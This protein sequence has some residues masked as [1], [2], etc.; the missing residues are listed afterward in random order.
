MARFI[1]LSI[2]FFFIAFTTLAQPK[3]P[4]VPRRT[5]VRAGQSVAAAS[6]LA[7][8]V[9]RVT[10]QSPNL[11]AFERYGEHPVSLFTGLASIEIPLYTIQAGPISVPITLSY[12]AGGHKV[13]DAASWVGLGWSL[14][15]GG[16]IT[17]QQRGMADEAQTV[18]LLDRSIITDPYAYFNTPSCYNE[19]V[20]DYYERLATGRLDAERDIFSLR[21]PQKTNQ[22]ILPSQ[23]NAQWLNPDV[24]K[25]TFDRAANSFALTDEQG[26]RYAFATPENTANGYPNAWLISQIQ[27]PQTADQIRFNY[28]PVINYQ[29]THEIIESQTINDLNA[30]LLAAGESFPPVKEGIVF[31][32]VSTA[33]AGRLP[34]QVLFP[35]GKIE[36][37][38]QSTDRQDQNGQALDRVEIYAYNLETST[39]SLLKAAWLTYEYYTRSG[40]NGLEKMLMLKQVTWKDATGS[41]INQYSFTY[42]TATALPYV[43]SRAKDYWGYAN[44]QTGNQTLIPAQTITTSSPGGS[45]SIGGGERNPDEAAMQAWLLTAITYP[46]GGSASFTYEAHQYADGPAS[47]LAGGL[48]IRQIRRQADAASPAVLSTYVYGTNRDGN[49]RLRQALTL[50]YETEQTQINYVADDRTPSSSP[51]RYYRWRIRRFTSNAIPALFPQEGS[52]VTYTTVTEYSDNGTSANGTAGRTV[53]TF[54]DSDDERITLNRSANYFLNSKHWDRGQPLTQTVYG[55]DGNKRAETINTYQ[56]QAAGQTADLTG[57]LLQTQ[58]ILGGNIRQ[59]TLNANCYA[60]NTDEYL[61]LQSYRFRYGITKL[62]KSQE[63]RYDELTEARFT[64]KTT[65]I[66]YD[67]TSLL[68]RQ[69]RQTVENGAILGSLLTYPQDFGPDIPAGSG[70]E[71]AGIRALQLR[72]T[73]LPVEQINYRQESLTATPVYTTGQLTTYKTAT[74]NG[75]DTA[76]PYQVYLSEAGPNRTSYQSLASRYLAAG[77][78]GTTLPTFDP[79]WA[80]PRLTKSGYDAYGNLTDYAPTGG[81]PVQL[82]YTRSVPATGA[83]FSTLISQTTNVNQPTQQQTRYTYQRPLV[84]VSTVTDPRGVTTTFEYDPFGRLLRI[85]DKDGSILKQYTYRYASQ[86]P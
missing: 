59:T 63:I 32:S 73:Y 84:G 79:L 75:M 86:Q 6:D 33:V 76:L 19:D 15:P 1:Y 25:I 56:V 69:T 70:G 5:A 2:P 38:L 17:R 52:A 40:N 8:L 37:I 4:L 11:A 80:S 43:Q 9:P 72:N 39:Y 85:K 62:V 13:T 65:E 74:I 7:N 49:G 18:G 61:P 21:I 35:G 78:N 28:H 20:R 83:A 81:S 57:Q 60:V 71:I 50:G 27:A 34:Q 64:S 44:G 46:T 55:A 3:L 58:T 31:A 16:A 36:F 51:Q 68:P 22:F 66:D 29:R 47:R 10:P 67:A 24:A 42:N 53:Y 26:I 45:Q 14:Q 82:A 48:R 23:T 54:R 41:P 77:G 12:H 30:G